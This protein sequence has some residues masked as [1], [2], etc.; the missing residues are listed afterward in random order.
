MGGALGSVARFA[1]NNLVTAK[2]G[3]AF[4]WG[5]LLVN[6]VGSLVIGWLGALTLTEGRL[7]E[8]GRTF[9]MQFLMVGVCGGFT[10]FSAFSLQTLMLLRDGEWFYAIG[11]MLLSVLLCLLAAGV[12]YRLGVMFG[13]GKSH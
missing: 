2:V 9:V 10:T 1:L 11:N 3:E 6:V 4:P 13:V 7:S 5:I 12:G 8:E